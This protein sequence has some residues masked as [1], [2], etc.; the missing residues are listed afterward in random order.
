M[1]SEDIKPGMFKY[2]VIGNIVREWI[3]EEGIK[4]NGIVVFPG[5]RKIYISRRLWDDEVTVLGINRWGSQYILERVPLAY[6]ENIRPSKT[7]NRTVVAL[8]NN[9]E[10]EDGW[11]RY[12][13]EDKIGSE[14]FAVMLN[15]M[16]AGN[17]ELYE[18]YKREVMSPYY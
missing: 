12:K 14:E 3:D 18:K 1:V 6:I 13:K 4:R 17:R 8:M 10:L 16:K 7:F 15:E 11:W 2:C 9:P 5:G